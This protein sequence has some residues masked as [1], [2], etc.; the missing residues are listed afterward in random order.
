[1]RAETAL[2]RDDTQLPQRV[3]FELPRALAR[4]LEARADLLERA[5]RLLA[6]VVDPE[7]EPE[8]LRLAL[9]Q[10][11][12]ERTR[13]GGELALGDLVVD[14]GRGRIRDDLASCIGCGCLS[15]RTCRLFNPVDRAA[16]AGPGARYLLGD[17]PGAA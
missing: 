14:G 6:G 13:V 8:D 17:E 15:L 10:R 3:A 7:A 9:R 2:V 5:R 4:Q 1:M 16:A 11:R 12:E